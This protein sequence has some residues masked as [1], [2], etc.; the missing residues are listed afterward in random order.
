M[1]NQLSTVITL[2][3]P[4]RSCSFWL[5]WRDKEYIS[6]YGKQNLGKR[7]LRI[8]RGLSLKC[9]YPNSYYTEIYAKIN[10]FVI[11]LQVDFAVY[12]QGV[13]CAY[14]L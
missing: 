7:P 6:I 8:R 13:N 11:L 4:I 14:F 3:L 10:V 5:G 1:L 2:P 12:C 9:F